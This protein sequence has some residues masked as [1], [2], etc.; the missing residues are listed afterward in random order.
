MVPDFKLTQG[1]AQRKIEV[2]ER[3]APPMGSSS[4]PLNP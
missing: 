1:L 4:E 3:V 2:F